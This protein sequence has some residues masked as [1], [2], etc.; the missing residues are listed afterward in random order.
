MG[1]AIR[2]YVETLNDPPEASIPKVTGTLPIPSR[3]RAILVPIRVVL[4]Q[5][6]L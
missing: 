6:R 3:R 1:A 4:A 5:G 2:S